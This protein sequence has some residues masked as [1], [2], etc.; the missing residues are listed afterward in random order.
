MHVLEAVPFKSS[1]T[2][3]S[4][5]LSIKDIFQ[6]EKKWSESQWRS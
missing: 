2:T 1:L 4:L 6:G 3:F 5:E